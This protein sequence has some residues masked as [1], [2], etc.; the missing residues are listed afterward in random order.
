MRHEKAFSEIC[1]KLGTVNEQYCG[2]ETTKDS[3]ELVPDVQSPYWRL[4]EVGGKPA[5]LSTGIEGFFF[6]QE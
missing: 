2:S 5:K 6:Y 1:Q 4:L 3:R